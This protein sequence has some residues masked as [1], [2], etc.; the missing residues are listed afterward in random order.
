MA[1]IFQNTLGYHS[2]VMDSEGSRALAEQGQCSQSWVAAVMDQR[3]LLGSRA[4]VTL[5]KG[6]FSQLPCDNW[7]SHFLK[8]DLWKESLF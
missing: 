3:V 8:L 6:G 1:N 2:M 5:G 4:S 7:V